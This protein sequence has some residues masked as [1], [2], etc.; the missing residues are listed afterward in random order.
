MKYLQNPFQLC[1]CPQNL[2]VGISQIIFLIAG[3]F[4]EFSS[5]I[6]SIFELFVAAVPWLSL[7]MQKLCP[8]LKCFS[9]KRRAQLQKKNFY[10]FFKEN[11]QLLMSC[12]ERRCIIPQLHARGSYLHKYF[13]NG[14]QSCFVLMFH[15]KL[16][17]W[18]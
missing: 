16:F 4:L 7:N 13:Y 3:V 1:L 6:L 18:S 10:L 12:T 9:I 8:L 15:L 14:F 5:N 2:F 17:I 11:S